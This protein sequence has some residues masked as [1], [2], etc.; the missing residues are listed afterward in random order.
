M[1]DLLTIWKDPREYLPFLQSLQELSPL[2]RNFTIDDFL[3]RHAKALVHLHAM[4]EYS[5][6]YEYTVKHSLYQQALHLCRYNDELIK[7][8]MRLYAD[9]L[10]LEGR[11][12]EA[13]TGM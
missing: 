6:F 11:H 3:G 7:D 9:Y 1:L 8:I 13:G 5:E 4:A 2:R 10:S 12:K